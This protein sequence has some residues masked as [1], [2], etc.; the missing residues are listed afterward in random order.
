MPNGTLIQIE[1]WHKSHSFIPCGGILAAYPKSKVS[2]KGAFSPKGNEIYRFSFSFS[3]KEEA[4]KAFD[5]LL[6][7]S[8][9]L[10]DFKANLIRPEYADCI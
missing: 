4:K 1:D 6:A 3:S 9:A 5:I 10:S 8:K 2:H 7:G